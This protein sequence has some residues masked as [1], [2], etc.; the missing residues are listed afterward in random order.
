MFLTT[1]QNHGRYKPIPNPTVTVKKF[2]NP[3]NVNTYLTGLK[4]TDDSIKKLLGY[5]KKVKEDVVVVFYGDHY[6]HCSYIPESIDWIHIARC[7]NE[8]Q[9]KTVHNS[10]L[11]M[12]KL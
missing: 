9:I 7:S 8:N 4:M 3:G 5:F 12:D 11:H 1:M 6:P 10:I 2:N